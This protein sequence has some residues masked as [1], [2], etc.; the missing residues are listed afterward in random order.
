[1]FCTKQLLQVLHVHEKKRV[2]APVLS[3]GKE[4][5]G[6]GGD[7][8]ADRRAQAASSGVLSLLAR[9]SQGL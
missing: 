3:A 8:A 2:L 4:E 1:M 9:D 7:H 6:I 5:R